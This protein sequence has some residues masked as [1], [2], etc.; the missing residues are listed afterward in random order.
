MTWYVKLREKQSK[1]LVKSQTKA[2]IFDEEHVSQDSDPDLERRENLKTFKESGISNFEETLLN[3]NVNLAHS[4]TEKS[5]S[6]KG[7][8]IR[9]RERTE[10]VCVRL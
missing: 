6:E 3:Q 10:S 9:S 7:G 8:I 4:D 1:K 5:S 2:N